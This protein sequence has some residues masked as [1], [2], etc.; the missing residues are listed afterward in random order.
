MPRIMWGSAGG[1]TPA[2]T[3]LFH[4]RSSQTDHDRMKQIRSI[5]AIARVR[6]PITYSVRAAPCA[7]SAA[8]IK[9]RSD[10]IEKTRSCTLR[11][12]IRPGWSCADELR[13]TAFGLEV[14]D[15]A[16]RIA[17]AEAGRPRCQSPP[18]GSC[19]AIIVS[20]RQLRSSLTRL[21]ATSRA[22]A[23]ASMCHWRAC[24]CRR[25]QHGPCSG[26]RHPAARFEYHGVLAQRCRCW[27]AQMRKC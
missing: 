4:R 27:S 17:T 24:C 25:P 8:I 1:F 6:A 22:H 26:Q 14:P 2:E 3:R 10:L 21:E 19:V 5:V 23:S 11:R 7:R 16:A 9:T 13:L 15:R 12:H 20:S 18:T